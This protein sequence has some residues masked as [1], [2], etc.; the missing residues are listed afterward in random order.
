MSKKDIQPIPMNPAPEKQQEKTQAQ[1]D[2]ESGM[3]FFTKGEFAQAAG[4][5]HN[6]LIGFEQE[7]NRQGMANAN[8]KLGDVCKSRNEYDKALVYYETA[9]EI[10]KEFDDVF[11]TM[12]LSG[13]QAECLSS[14]GKYKDAINICLDLLETHQKMRNPD[15]SVKTLL[16][17]AD[18]YQKAGNIDGCIDA[19]KTAASIH[20]N[21]GHVNAARS[22]QEKIAAL[23]TNNS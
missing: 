20:A 6:A 9:A 5:F 11:S 12:S 14:Q 15:S 23:E 19:Y 1:A 17:I 7:G 16:I 2:Y 18:I 13:K 8:D 10:C 4:F 22:L 21:F 3:D